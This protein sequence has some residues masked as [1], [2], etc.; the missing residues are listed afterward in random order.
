MI[1]DEESNPILPVQYAGCEPTSMKHCQYT[2]I[3]EK[4][5]NGIIEAPKNVDR[6]EALGD[7]K[8]NE[9]IRRD[10]FG[11]T[12]DGKYNG[13]CCNVDACKYVL[14]KSNVVAEIREIIEC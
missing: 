11:L 12:I 8:K 2:T 7:T 10:L 14:S 13:L 1:D 3:H 9:R 6:V 4:H 5:S